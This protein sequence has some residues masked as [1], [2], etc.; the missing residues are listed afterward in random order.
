MRAFLE[1]PEIRRLG[2]FLGLGLLAALVTGPDGSQDRPWAGFQ[3]SILDVR[4]LD[5]VIPAIVLALAVDLYR[6]RGDRVR[7]VVARARQATAVPMERRSFKLSLYALI[8][9]FVVLYPLRLS[10][11]WLTVLVDQIGIYV[12]LAIGLNVVVGFAGL[13]D[14]GYIAF[15]AIGAYTTAYFTGKL[16]AHPPVVL[17]PFLI[18]PVAVLIAM[19]AGL[20]LGAPTLRLRGDYL[21]IVTLGF[22]EIVRITAV[23]TDSFTNGPRGTFGVP[24]FSINLGPIHY[25]WTLSQLPYYYLLLV[26]IGVVW[27]ALARLEDSRI[28]RAW[29]AIREDEVAAEA[30][31]VPT[32]KL[33]LMAFAIG[34]STSGFAG[35]LFA[36]KVGSFTPDN[37]VLL[38]SI[39]VLVMV[40]F[41]GMGS[42]PGAI[43]GAVV[44]GWLPEALRG[45]VPPTDRFIYFGA[46][47]VA[48]MIF[49]PQGLLPSKR[50][51]R[52]IA[53][54]EHPEAVL[55]AAAAEIDGGVTP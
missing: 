9:L 22:G 3:H 40:I 35:V 48:M 8:G 47:L 15:Y 16:P 34:A 13:L 12:L 33:K 43:L 28:G 41:G 51:A 4:V 23:N 38:Q 19:L 42:I 46:L 30:S 52:E 18:F 26:V 7:V 11:Y 6:T 49:R 24:H 31:G 55:G 10:N 45:R 54:T 25:K 17:N 20:L 50:R 27:F 29:T 44:L 37:F 2:V 36:S 21:A 1:R 5:F 53:I 39:L 32:L 14:L